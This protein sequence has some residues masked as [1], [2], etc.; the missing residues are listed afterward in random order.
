MTKVPEH[1]Y[2]QSAVIPY[3]QGV[4]GLE[5]LLITSRKKKRWVIPKGVKERHMSAQASAANEALEEAGVEGRVHE[6]ALGCYRYQKWGG[7]CTVEVFAMFVETVHEEW[8]EG[9]RDRRWLPPEQ[10]AAIVDEEALKGLI[11]KLPAWIAA[12]Q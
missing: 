5:V 2:K 1:F 6:R 8:L 7:E 12:G 3:R 11:L 9:H 10:A 4:G